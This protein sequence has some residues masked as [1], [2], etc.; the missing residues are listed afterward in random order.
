VLF[1]LGALLLLVTFPFDRDRRLLHGLVCRWCHWLWLHAFPG[2]RTRIEGRE[3]LPRGAC[4]LVVNHQSAVDILAVMGLFHPYKFVAKAS[5]FSLPLVGWMMTLL[6]YV[7]I[8][9][10]SSTA[11]HQLLSPCRKWLRR[12]MSVLIFPEGTYSTGGQL[13]PFKRGAF[14][15]ALEEH[16][17]VV[18]VV[19]EG[20]PQLLEGDGPWMSPRAS[21]RVRVLPPLPPESFGPDAAE[22]AS[23]VRSLYEQTLAAAG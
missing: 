9:R 19:V 23:R 17:P 2:W 22:L 4:V 16:V 8:V 6:A 14:Q 3:L 10:G 15:L 21:I 5:L 7:P 12:G 13:L 18:P 11:M 1:T 20:T